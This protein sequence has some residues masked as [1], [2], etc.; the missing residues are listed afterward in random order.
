MELLGWADLAVAAAVGTVK[1][2]MEQQIQAVVA[3][4]V[5]AAH[6]TKLA[7]AVQ[8]ALG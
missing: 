6:Q 4:A 7:A 8:A 2:K 3:V 5:L 1:I